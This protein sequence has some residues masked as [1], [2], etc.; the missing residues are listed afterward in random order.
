MIKHWEI[1]FFI[2]GALLLAMSWERATLLI[3]SGDE[4][5]AEVVDISTTQI[6]HCGRKNIF[7]SLHITDRYVPG[8]TYHLKAGDFVLTTNQIEKVSVG[9]KIPI[10]FSENKPDY[11]HV[12]GSKHQNPYLMFFGGII[13]M[14]CGIVSF[15]FKN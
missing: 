13:F 11:V 2:V 6:R 12:I 10:I 9:K 8:Y 5:L 1:V 3:L 4:H 7:C 14:F 15:V